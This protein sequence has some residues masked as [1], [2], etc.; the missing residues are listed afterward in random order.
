M[1]KSMDSGIRGRNYPGGG[2]STTYDLM[3]QCRAEM[4]RVDQDWRTSAM[5][6]DSAK[7]QSIDRERFYPLEREMSRILS[8]AADFGMSEYILSFL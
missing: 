6:E 1:A 3:K 8:D 2:M 7:C 5:A 4:E